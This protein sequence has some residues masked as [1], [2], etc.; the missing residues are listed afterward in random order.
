[1]ELIRLSYDKRK[2]RFR[3][4]GSEFG[5]SRVIRLTPVFSANDSGDVERELEAFPSPV[6]ANAYLLD[7]KNCRARLYS[8]SAAEYNLALEAKRFVEDERM[9]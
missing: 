4:Y 3:V 9:R 8:L 5:L 6:P 2:K 7:T 1:M